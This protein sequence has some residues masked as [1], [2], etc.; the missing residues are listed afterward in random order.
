MRRR[1]LI[2]LV[3]M[4]CGIAGA[5]AEELT[6]EQ[7]LDLARQFV[8]GQQGK[9]VAAAGNTVA[10]AGLISGL[11][12]FNVG[13]DGGFV[14]VSNDDQTAPI[15]GYSD[16]GSID[17]DNLPANLS[18]WLQSYADQ[19]AWVKANGVNGTHRA[20]RTNRTMKTAVDPLVETRWS[21]GAPY[22]N[23][24][25]TIDG[26]KTVTGCVATTMAQIMYYH[27][28]RNSFAASSTAVP[29]YECTTKDKNKASYNLTVSALAATDF[30][31]TNMTTT[32][33]TN[34]T[35][36]P[37]DAVAQLMLYCGTAIRMTYGL[38]DNG[39]SSAYSEAIP[40]ALKTYFGYDGGIQ[41]CYRKNYSYDAWVDLIYSELSKRRPVALGGQSGGGGHSFIC[42]GYDDND[43]N[44][45][46][47]DYFHI[48]WGWG[49]SSDGYFLLS[50]L[51][52]YEQGIGGSSSLDGFSY[53]Q[54]A[55]IGIQPPVA[56]NA[57][58][59]LSLEGLYLDEDVSASSKE[60]TRATSTDPFTGISLYYIV[61]DYYF[62]VNAFDTTV[63]LVDES[64]K[65][66]KTFDVGAS[67]QTMKWNETIHGTLSLSIPSDVADGT[68]IIKVM[69]R[70]HGEENWQECHDGDAY[71]LTA[72]INGNSLTI[73]VPIP[74]NVLPA[75]VTFG[76]VTGDKMTGHEHT[77][78][79]TITGGEGKYN[80]EIFLHVNNKAV[81]GTI[82]NI[83]AG[84]TQ[85][86][87]LSFNP[88][89]AGPT[90]I[91]LYA[92][93]VLLGTETSIGNIAFT[94]DNKGDNTSIIKA[95]NGK[96]TDATLNG[97]TLYKDGK[98]NTLCLPFDVTIAGSPL[99]G[100]EAR[101]L[102]SASIT[103]TTLTLNF[104]DPVTTLQAGT[105]YIIKWASGTDIKNPVF[106]GV[107]IDNSD[108]A[109]ARMKITSEDGRV[110]FKGLYSSHT[111]TA[112]DMRFLLVGANNTLYWPKAGTTLGT[113]RAYFQIAEEGQ[114]AP[115]IN[116]FNLTF[117]DDSTQT[118]IGH[119]EITEI[120]E[121][122]DAWY[123][124]DGRKLQDTPTQKGVYIYKGVK[125]VIK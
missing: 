38:R 105:P 88:Q 65:V 20:N 54:D 80:G 101:T 116:S 120:T 55:V 6:K 2:F 95:N 109:T 102:S 11:Y 18:A 43:H 67:N 72:V 12:V 40:F 123:T 112:D 108:E 73:D 71:K 13:I 103:G 84:E 35:G 21:Q 14:I 17:P 51:D 115:A 99:D 33:T 106:T 4:T 79:A 119:T 96:T 41:H 42:D 27:Y 81:M 83:G 36:A 68:Y 48:N 87:Q 31:W 118:G 89:E 44:G 125:R 1:L 60:F 15:L 114:Q 25:P 107:T 70:I 86:L 74:I 62:G 53:G 59:C 97:R 5:W 69:S 75:S 91:A 90:T 77:V 3:L 9:R 24:C 45:A 46:D 22:N 30:D 19:I 34:S 8:A 98:W 56:G 92:S 58:Y 52:P 7:A 50:V 111:F 117:G 76:E 49:G 82:L 64:G 122:S 37:A 23:Q 104:S 113:Q 10:E 32:Y 78:T 94:L 28:A 61:Y 63:Q 66:V 16:S 121:N 124:L 57:D 85:K 39:G 29:G 26:T 47:G 93:G 100:A 110:Q